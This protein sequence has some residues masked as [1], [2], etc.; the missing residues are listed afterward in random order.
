MSNIKSYKLFEASLDDANIPLYYLKP[1]KQIIK[2][3]ELLDL[4]KNNDLTNFKEDF[5]GWLKISPKYRNFKFKVN[6]LNI[7]SDRS[8]CIL[9]FIFK[10]YFDDTGEYHDRSSELSI[11]INEDTEIQRYIVIEP[12]NNTKSYIDPFD[13]EDWDWDLF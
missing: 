2:G 1:T 10:R 6:N 12:I 9:T 5:L 13:E 3:K 11:I 8:R 7:T 4:I